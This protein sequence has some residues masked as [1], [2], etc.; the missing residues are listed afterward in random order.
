MTS[1]D[2]PVVANGRLRLFLTATCNLSCFYCHNEGQPKDGEFS[3]DREMVDRA[4]ELGAHGGIDKLILSG[5]E[6]LMHPDV[7]DYVARLSPWVRRASLITNGILLTADMAHGLRDAGLSKIRLGVDSFRPTKPRPSPGYLAEPFDVEEVV[8]HTMAAGLQLDL[9]VVLTRFNQ[10]EIPRFLRFAIDR[11]IDIKFF[12][13]LDVAAPLNGGTVNVMAPKP[14]VSEEFFM[15]T[16]TGELGELPDFV[17]TDEFAPATSAARVAS[18][19][20]RYCRYLCT[21]GRCASPGTRLDAEG[22]VY[23]CMSNRG[24]DRIR[25]EMS[26]PEIRGTFVRASSRACGF[27][28]SRSQ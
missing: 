19:E 3:I 13:H 8:D 27:S 7:V 22:F 16:L 2:A 20:I 11:G 17:M 14:H 1:V 6:P 21:Y 4:V 26:F 12:E 5:G 23:T 15:S 25:S 18:T 10:T 28:Q 24:L 9:N